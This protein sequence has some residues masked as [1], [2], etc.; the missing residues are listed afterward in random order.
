MAAVPDRRAP[1]SAPRAFRLARRGVPASAQRWGR[2]R[3]P[4]RDEQ[5]RR[6]HH[7]HRRR[8]ARRVAVLR[9]PRRA[10][11][12]P[13]SAG[14]TRRSDRQGRQHGQREDDGA[15]PAL[16]DLQPRAG[17]PVP[18]HP[19]AEGA[20]A[21]KH[22]ATARAPGG[23]HAGELRSGAAARRA[24]E[25]GGAAARSGAGDGL[26][27]PRGPP[28][29]LAD[30]AARWRHGPVW[31]PGLSARRAGRLPRAVGV[32]AHPGGVSPA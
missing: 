24:A 30:P 21:A 29:V 8:R 1:T 19:R 3:G 7:L 6:Q 9:A 16:R 28:R 27:G 10:A 20:A 5:P 15:A 26:R 25:G 18:V 17:R 11:R 12:G 13:R 23:A 32:R 2:R 31:A 22:G 4:G 14:P